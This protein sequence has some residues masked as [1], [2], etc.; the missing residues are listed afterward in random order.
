[1]VGTE[2]EEGRRVFGEGRRRATGD[3]AGWQR[4]RNRVRGKENGLK[5]GSE[6]EIAKAQHR[7]SEQASE[8]AQG[9]TRCASTRRSDASE[10]RNEEQGEQERGSGM[11]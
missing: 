8:R 9:D 3:E 2:H 7:A 5:R 10:R 4:R 1:M 6:N 11:A